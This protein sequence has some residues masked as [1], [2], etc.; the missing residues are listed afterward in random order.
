MIKW[1]TSL[2][3]QAGDARGENV[4]NDLELSGEEINWITPGMSVLP[5]VLAM[6]W[7]LKTSPVKTTS[8]SQPLIKLLELHRTL[9]N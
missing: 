8:Q 1:E 9:V 5:T 3:A 4:G 7:Q 2:Q 6:L